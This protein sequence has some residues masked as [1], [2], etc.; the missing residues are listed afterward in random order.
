M[1][2]I[3]ITIMEIRTSFLMDEFVKT[4]K[5]KGITIKKVIPVSFD[6]IERKKQMLPNIKFKTARLE[7]DFTKQKIARIPNRKQRISS[8]L[9]ILSTT[10]V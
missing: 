1:T 8:R 2:A 5:V 3:T 7:T 6:N 10:S 4:N 9:L